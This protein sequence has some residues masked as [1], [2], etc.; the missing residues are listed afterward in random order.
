MSNQGAQSGKNGI[1]LHDACL[2]YFA[3]KGIKVV[4]EHKTGIRNALSPK[5][6]LRCDIYLPDSDVIVE[7]KAHSGQPGTIYQK[8]PHSFMTYADCVKPI[9]FI[10]G[11]GF[12]KFPSQIEAV[13]R[14]ASLTAAN[15][16]IILEDEL[17]TGCWA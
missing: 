17:D 8:I 15:I 3:Q 13:K 5:S 9:V 2:A 10:L 11:A 16:T 12:R 6:E 14:A 4:K 1:K 7:C